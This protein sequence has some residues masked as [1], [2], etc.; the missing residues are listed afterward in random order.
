MPDA[1]VDDPVRIFAREFVGIGTAVRVWCTIGVTF[2][3]DGRYG[4]DR[5][6][7]KPL[8]QIVIF[9]LAFSQAEPPAVIMDDD[10]DMIRIVEGRRTAIEGCIIDVPLRRSELPDDSEWQAKLRRHLRRQRRQSRVKEG[11]NG[12]S[13]RREALVESTDYWSV[14]AECLPGNS[15]Q[16]VKKI[17]TPALVRLAHH[18]HELAA[19]VERE[20]PR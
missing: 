13:W 9:R 5:A 1:A 14:L 6:C 10:A 16:S 2:K 8:F 7:S 18:T 19:G 15:Y 4:D 11:Q 3:G 17:L 12:I 20:R